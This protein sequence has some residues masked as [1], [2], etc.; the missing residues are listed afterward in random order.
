MN[1]YAP[2][3]QLAFH[4]LGLEYSSGVELAY[5]AINSSFDP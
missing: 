1:T 4:P 5:H 2:V 3:N